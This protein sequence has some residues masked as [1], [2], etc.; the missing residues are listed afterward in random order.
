VAVDTG[1]P[2][3]PCGLPPLVDVGKVGGVPTSKAV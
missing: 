3:R 2:R 1:T